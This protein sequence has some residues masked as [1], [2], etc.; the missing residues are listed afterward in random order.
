MNPPARPYA[1]FAA[2]FAAFVIHAGLAD[3]LQIFGARPNLCTLVLL[4]C[5]LYAGPGLG[6]GLG[7]FAGLLEASFTPLYFGSL[8]ATRLLIGAAVGSLEYR[9]YR[10][11][12]PFALL[13]VVI[14]TPLVEALFY[15]FA[16][17]PD[18]AAWF[19]GVAKQTAYHAVLA[20]PAYFLL[21]RAV[22]G[23]NPR[24]HPG[25]V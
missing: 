19:L 22:H 16:P 8:L 17:Q 21:R 1:L 9:V 23:R 3:D 18:S 25:R 5:C 10:D 4:I 11:N 20:L 13:T 15:L 12:A 7:F 2:V 14:G 24:L 6:A